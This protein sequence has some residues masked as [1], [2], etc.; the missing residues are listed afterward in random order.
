MKLGWWILVYMNALSSRLC[1]WVCMSVS[2]H[3]WKHKIAP[4]FSIPEDD[5]VKK[6]EYPTT[7][8]TCSGDYNI[9]DEEVVCKNIMPIRHDSDFWVFVL[10]PLTRWDAAR[11]LQATRHQILGTGEKDHQEAH[12]FLPLSTYLYSR[13]ARWTMLILPHL[14][15]NGACILSAAIINNFIAFPMAALASYNLYSSME[16]VKLFCW[17]NPATV[18]FTTAYS[19]SIFASLTFTGYALYNTTPIL[20]IP[21]WMAASYTRSNGTF[22]TGYIFLYQLGNIFLQYNNCNYKRIL[23]IISLTILTMTLV[24]IPFLYHD[25][26]GY[27]NHCTLT[28]DKSFWCDH[29]RQKYGIGMYSTIQK[30]H[31]NVG[32]FHYYQIKQIPNFILAAPILSISIYA[33]YKWIYYSITIYYNNYNQQKNQI[34]QL[35]SWAIWSLQEQHYQTKNDLVIDER[36]MVTN[37]GK[38]NVVFEERNLLAQYAMLAPFTIVCLVLAHIQIAT[39]VLASSCPI[40]YWF[41]TKQNKLLPWYK[42][43]AILYGILGCILHVNWLP[44]T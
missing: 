17:Y 18:F 43:Y 42:A 41:L 37:F 21:F 6:F 15:F 7:I 16:V 44:W 30:I 19:E 13:M 33:I 10:E 3:L 26:T 2:C 24:A 11:F 14:S 34:N 12:A 25:Y 36:D 27:Q 39:R 29:V 23:F 35:I 8:D 38:K 28:Q 32:L 9:N 5:S 40:L 22:I 31:W 20:A 4:Y 1:T